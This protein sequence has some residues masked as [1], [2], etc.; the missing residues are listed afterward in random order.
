MQ[1]EELT[2]PD[3]IFPDLPGS[4]TPTVLRA[5]ADRAEQHGVVGNADLLYQRLFEREELGSTGI[6][7]GVAIPHCKIAGLD[8]VKMAVAIT[9]ND[10]DFGATDDRPVRLF[11]LIVSPDD[12]PADHLQALAAVSKWLKTD[13]HVQQILGLQNPAQIYELLRAERV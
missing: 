4:D 7:E 1:I 3:L 6:G 9:T 5:L 8:G 12:N 10:V 11:V 13:N 2:T